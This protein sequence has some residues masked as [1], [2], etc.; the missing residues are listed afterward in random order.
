MI[1]QNLIDEFKLFIFSDY[2]VP[3]TKIFFDN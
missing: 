3:T 2:F 1:P